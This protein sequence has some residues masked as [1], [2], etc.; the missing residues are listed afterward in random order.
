MQ[1][2]TNI[3]KCEKDEKN[4]TEEWGKRRKM[5]EKGREKEKPNQNEIKSRTTF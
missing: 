4:W 3:V 2:E 1:N 5:E